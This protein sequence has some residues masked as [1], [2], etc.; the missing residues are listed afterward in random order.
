[1]KLFASIRKRKR[2]LLFKTFSQNIELTPRFLGTE[3]DRGRQRDR[4]TE[5]NTTQKSAC[6]V[7][8]QV[9]AIATM[10]VITFGGDKLH[11]I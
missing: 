9:I 1:M 4:E 6:R 11:L 10:G 2:V 5:S 7:M 3:V 8:P